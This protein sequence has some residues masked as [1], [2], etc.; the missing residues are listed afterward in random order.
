VLLIDAEEHPEPES[1][2]MPWVEQ[3]MQLL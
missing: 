1:V 2:A 3:W